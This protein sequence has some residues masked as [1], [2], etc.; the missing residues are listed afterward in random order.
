[1]PGEAL[2][3]AL[4]A[5][6]ARAEAGDVVAAR[7]V[8]GYLS[9]LVSQGDRM[10][11]CASR[12]LFNALYRISNGIDANQALR[13]KPLNKR[14][15]WTETE[16]RMAVAEMRKY[17]EAPNSLPVDEAAHRAAEDIRNLVRK[18]EAAALDL[19]LRSRTVRE[20]HGLS[21][22]PREYAGTRDVEMYPWGSFS[23]RP[24]DEKTIRSWHFKLKSD[25]T[26]NAT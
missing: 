18:A 12:F 21:A 24:P 17:L 1:M 20:E 5:L 4:S 3:L 14:R 7:E 9:V 15:P 23:R 6:I 2:T 19:T 26:K 16:K 8:A 25:D 10:P 13:V 11:Q 22:L